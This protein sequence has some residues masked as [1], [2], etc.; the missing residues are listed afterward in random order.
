M[1]GP[2][3]YEI[4][5]APEL[6][7]RWMVPETWVRN[8]TRVGYDNDPLPHIRLGKYVRYE[9]GSPALLAWWERRRSKRTK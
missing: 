7:K 9:F 2:M 6:G 8:W 3:I 4:V 5:D 1:D